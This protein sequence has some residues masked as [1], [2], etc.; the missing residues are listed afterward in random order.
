VLDLTT[1]RAHLAR[2]I[3]A[4]LLLPLL[5][6]C[7]AIKLGYNGL[8]DLA[9]WWLDGY[10][11]FTEAQ[12]PLVRG[13]LGRL[14]AWHR[15]QELPR[16]ADVLARMEQLAAGPVTPAQACDFAA[17]VEARLAG[18]A[19]QAEPAAA[20]LALVLEPRQLRHLERK[21]R[22]NNADWRRNWIDVAPDE[23]S[24]KRYEQA[25]DRAESIYGRLDEPQRAVLRQWAERSPFDALRVLAERQRRQ[26]DLLQT[27]RRLQEAADDPA[28]ARSALREYVARV[29]RSP[30]ADYRRYRDEVL[31]DACGTFASLHQSTTPAQRE[32]AARRLRAYQ[33]DLRELAAQ[34]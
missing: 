3:G 7:S 1:L 16:L 32:Q 2:I 14:H 24:T 11:D 34:R 8:P 22:G 20:A 19:S 4:L 12:T 5:A 21:Y 10:F 17:E 9:Y 26:Q 28:G 33:R 25:L 18:V 13:E 15:A 6:G 30:D 29:Q 31:Q 27:L 23:R